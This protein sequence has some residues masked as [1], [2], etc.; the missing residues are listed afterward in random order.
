M[1]ER[2]TVDAI[3]FHTHEAY[4]TNERQNRS[5]LVWFGRIE[6]WVYD[7]QI[8]G[9]QRAGSGPKRQTEHSPRVA[10][11]NPNLTVHFYG[12]VGLRVTRAVIYG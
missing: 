11:T 1:F 6:F 9:G 10:Y 5:G 8:R 7:N 3:G 4:G 12:L 2:E